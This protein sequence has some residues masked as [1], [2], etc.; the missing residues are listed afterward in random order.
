MGL[1]LSNG[2][3]V[4]ST[5]VSE[6]LRLST[7]ADPN[8]SSHWYIYSKFPAHLTIPTKVLYASENLFNT[9]I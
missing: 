8:E 6:R 5:H 7:L 1:I 9:C 4:G 2:R 3:A